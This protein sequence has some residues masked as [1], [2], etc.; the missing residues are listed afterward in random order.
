MK[1]NVSTTIPTAKIGLTLLLASFISLLCASPANASTTK[2]TNGACPVL[3][4]VPQP[5]RRS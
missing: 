4:W 2:L 5:P 3:G 1:N